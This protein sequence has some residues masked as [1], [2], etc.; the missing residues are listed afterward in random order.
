MR[1]APSVRRTRGTALFVGLAGAMALSLPGS[2][3]AHDKGLDHP[4]PWLRARAP[5]RRP[6]PSTPGGPDAEWELVTSV[7]TGNPHTDIDFFT[8]VARSSRSSARSRRAERRRAEHRP[9]D[10]DRRRG[11][12]GGRPQLLLLAPSASCVS[13]PSRALGT[14]ARRRGHAEEPRHRQQLRQLPE[15]GLADAQLIID[16]TDA[17][18]AATTRASSAS[19]RPQRRPGDR[20]HHRPEN[21]SRSAS[22]ATSA[23][24]TR[25]TSTRS[26]RTSPTR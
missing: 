8:S 7:P 25:S 9:A 13:N 2:A 17:E 10:R 11:H 18:A 20:R 19:R 4:A 16:A 23:S 24:R 15:D 22:P 12:A 5:C 6:R 26:A 3:V 14:A 1:S 21:P